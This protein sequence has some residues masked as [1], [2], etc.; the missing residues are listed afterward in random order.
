M[1]FCGDSVRLCTRCNSESI[2]GRSATH[3]FETPITKFEF[4][5]LSAFNHFYRNTL[6]QKK[7][8]LV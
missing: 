4:C 7:E 1:N 8:G 6:P 2:L 3:S 5:N